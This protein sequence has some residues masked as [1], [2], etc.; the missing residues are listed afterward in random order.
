MKPG[1]AKLA[2]GNY[3]IALQKSE[4]GAVSLIERLNVW[5]LLVFFVSEVLSRVKRGVT[6]LALLRH[7][8]RAFDPSGGY[9]GIATLPRSQ[10]LSHQAPPGALSRA[11]FDL[12]NVPHGVFSA[13]HPRI[14]VSITSPGDAASQSLVAQTYIHYTTNPAFRGD[15]AYFLSVPGNAW[16]GVNAFD[17]MVATALRTNAKVVYADVFIGELQTF[18]FA[19]DKRFHTHADMLSELVMVARSV[20]DN[21]GLL[22]GL[23]FK[24][25]SRISRPLAQYNDPFNS[26][27]TG[28]RSTPPAPKTSD[29]QVSCIIPTRD[30]VGLLACITQGLLDHSEGVKDII[31]VDNGSV[32]T[33]TFALFERLKMR[34]VKIVRDGGDFNF[35]RLCNL[36]ASHAESQV[37]A[38]I[39]NDI[40]V[41]HHDWLVQMA[42][43]ALRPNVGAVGTRLLYKDGSLQHGGIALGMFG[44]SGH[45][46]RHWPRE[47][48][49]R[50][51]SL[52]HAGSRSA[53]TG[54]VLIVEAAKFNRVGGFDAVH[55]PVT[56]NDIDLCLRLNVLGFGCV[57]EPAGEAYHLEGVSRGEDSSP[58]KKERRNAELR[59]F[60]QK[61]AKAIEAELWFSPALSRTHESIR[62]L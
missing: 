20:A 59:Y 49:Q 2:A 39:N 58:E 29:Q 43:Q 27:T 48:W 54:A 6:P 18:S 31:I 40:Q 9:G 8:F 11:Y 61:W 60:I 13:A 37:L 14:F 53:V 41:T 46:F 62:L 50:I 3:I 38:F 1:Y 19:F 17:T 30:Q 47:S 34:G 33:E 21:D 16:L 42:R 52:V 32:E 23:T 25:I 4:D 12:L 26:S 5:Q 7:A 35:S 45:P 57:Y 24:D 55:F 28:R 15:C 22:N 10:V 36:G 56:M 44:H 51:P